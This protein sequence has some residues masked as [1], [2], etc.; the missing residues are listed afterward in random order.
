MQSPCFALY[1]DVLQRH[2]CACTGSWEHKAEAQILR[3]AQAVI[4]QLVSCSAQALDNASE[5][6][7][8]LQAHAFQV[9]LPQ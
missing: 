9:L 5:K 3:H 7:H 4:L 8:G 6:L 2:P 1:L